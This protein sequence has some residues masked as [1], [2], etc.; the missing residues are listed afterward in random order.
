MNSMY[1]EL[2]RQRQREDLADATNRRLADR[3]QAAHRWRRAEAWAARRRRDAERAQR[4]A[5]DATQ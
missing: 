2:V 4:E 3:V 5:N 1:E